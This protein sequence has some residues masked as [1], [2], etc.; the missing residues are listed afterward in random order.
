ML[1]DAPQAPGI[2]EC[3]ISNMRPFRCPMACGGT[4]WPRDACVSSWQAISR[5][6]WLPQFGRTDTSGRARGPRMTTIAQFSKA[7]DA[8]LLRLRLE[9]GGVAAYIQDENTSQAD[10]LLSDA[11]GGVKVEV[12]DE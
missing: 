12:D 10:W 11:I 2:D 6:V 3:C 5:F 4:S 8:H 1:L 9:A 7:E